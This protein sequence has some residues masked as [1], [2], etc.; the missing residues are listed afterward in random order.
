MLGSQDM[1][2]MG[3]NVMAHDKALYHGHPVAAVAA[4]SDE[5]AARGAAS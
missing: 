3:R 1:R 5:I 2:W 4:T